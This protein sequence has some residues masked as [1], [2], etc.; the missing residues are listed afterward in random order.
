MPVRIIRVMGAAFSVHP[1]VDI[2][3]MYNN[4]QVFSGAVNTSGAEAPLH[5]EKDSTVI[6][7]SFESTT[8]I[9]GEIPLS[10]SVTGGVVVFVE[11]QGNYS[12]SVAKL[13]RINPAVPVNAND[14]TT[15]TIDSTLATGTLFNVRANPDVEINLADPSTFTTS[16][17]VRPIDFNSSLSVNSKLDKLNVTV[18]GASCSPDYTTLQLFQAGAEGMWHYN[19]GSGATLACMYAVDAGKILT[20]PAG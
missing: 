8:D 14:S 20:T 7:C 17:V 5:L 9:T 18:D 3:V 15:Y 12:G 13:D 6:L 16:T 11:L 10:I 1:T 19:I 4:V 2:T